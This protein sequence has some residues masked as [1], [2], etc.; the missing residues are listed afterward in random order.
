M[1][2]DELHEFSAEARWEAAPAI[3]LVIAGQIL[4]A[5]LSR[6][7][8]WR[9]SGL[10][11]WHWLVAVA[12]EL[13]LI[14]ALTHEVP[15]SRLAELGHLRN[16]AIL[17]VG[18]I[19]VANSVSLA[20]L[21]GSLVNGHEHSGAELLLK[22]APIWGTNVVAF[23]LWFWELDSGGPIARRLNARR[24]AP[25]PP[26]DFQFPQ[27]ENPTLA[28]PDWHP[29]LFDYIYIAFTNAIA[30][31]PTDAMPL[32]RPAKGL[33][34]LESAISALTVLLVAARAVNILS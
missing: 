18:V 16:A 26:A 10:P 32:S 30:F 4:L 33:M 31:S 3:A 19:T 1:G 23:G 21:I 17:L 6:E 5:L 34:L 27:Q 11:W 8:G 28:A 29:H 9:L 22:G 24:Q 12:P 2:S 15:R 7:S 13:V 20:A 14:G 25:P